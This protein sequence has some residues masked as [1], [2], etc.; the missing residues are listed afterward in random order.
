[1]FW[2]AVVTMFVGSFVIQSN[3]TPIGLGSDANSAGLLLGVL[4]VLVGGL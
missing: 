3:T 2:G 1:V 4:I